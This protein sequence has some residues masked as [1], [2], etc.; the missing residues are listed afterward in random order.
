MRWLF[1]AAALLACASEPIDE[2]TATVIVRGEA[3][4]ECV[5]G[6]TSSVMVDVGAEPLWECRWA[7]ARLPTGEIGCAVQTWQLTSSGWT[8]T[9]LA[10]CAP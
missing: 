6:Q 2:H 5:N 10:S 3:E 8:S 4:I 9:R 1:V 7:A